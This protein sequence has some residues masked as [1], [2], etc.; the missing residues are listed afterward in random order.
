MLAG[1]VAAVDASGGLASPGALAPTDQARMSSAI[2]GMVDG[3]AARLA[4]HPEDGEGWVRLVRAYTVLGER[5]KRDAALAEARRRF[6]DRPAILSELSA[7]AQGP[8]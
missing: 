3:L 7:A 2:R 4:A 5:E 1:D 6:A 8:G